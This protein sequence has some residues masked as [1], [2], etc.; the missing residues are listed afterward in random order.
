MATQAGKVIP[1]N[2]TPASLEALNRLRSGLSQ[3]AS[4]ALNAKDAYMHGV[5][6]ELLALVSRK[7]LKA[8]ARMAREQ[9]AAHRRQHKDLRKQSQVDAF[10]DD[11][12]NA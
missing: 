6:T 10:N 1:A 3:S 11:V 5:Y 4:E 2:I 8:Q 12:D 7:V 9:V